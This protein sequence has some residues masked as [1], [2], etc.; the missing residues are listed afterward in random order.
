MQTNQE[1]IKR[2]VDLMKSIMSNPK[3]S[4]TFKDAMAAPIGSTKRAQAKTILSIMKKLG[5]VQNDGVG[6]P[7][8]TNTIENH[9]NPDLSDFSNLMIFPAAPKFR[10]RTPA[11][12]DSK[13]TSGDGQGGPNDNSTSTPPF[14]FSSTYDPAASAS[15]LMKQ[16]GVAQQPVEQPPKPVV[17][18]PVTPASFPN[19]SSPTSWTGSDSAVTPGALAGLDAVKSIAAQPPQTGTNATSATQPGGTTG[20]TTGSTDQTGATTS[21]GTSTTPSSS[22][23]ISTQYPNLSAGDKLKADAQSAVDAGTGPGLFAMGVADNKFG[24]SL[25]QYINNLD[26]KLKTDFN[27][28]PLET[29]LSNLKAE[30]GNLVPTLQTYMTGKDQ[31]MSFIDNMITQAEG[32]LTHTDMGNPAEAA[33][34]T[35]YLN[36]LYTLKGRQNTRY[37]NFLNAAISDYNA[38]V[39]RT[40]ANYDSVYKNYNDA[41]TRGSTIAQTEY[42]TL[43]QT[44]GDLYNSLDQ[45][46]TKRLN[47][48]I[49]QQQK[50]ANALA[51]AKNALDQTN[52]TNPKFWTDVTNLTKQLT[53]SNATGSAQNDLDFTKLGAGGLAGFFAAN[54]YSGS[55]P[56]AA[57]RAINNTM[58]ATLADT[59]TV[60]NVS[61][62]KKLVT[63]LAAAPGGDK[64]AAMLTPTLSQSAYPVVSGYVKS[65]LGTIKKAVQQ[66]VTDKKNGLSNK[67][68]WMSNFSNL[69]SGILEDIYNMASKNIIPGS[70]YEK[71]PSSFVDA[72]FQGSNDSA[73]ASNVTSILMS[74]W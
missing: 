53:D 22:T 58:A 46:P 40:Q 69:D 13:K 45:A 17:P 71:N 48:E 35:N 14:S 73:V 68:G 55:D 37:G 10:A 43:Y 23:P 42:N 63:E 33:N 65:N 9:S 38:D 24:G 62:L 6:G 34:Y 39:D 5:G 16:G 64:A 60:E 67:T 15:N 26:T 66:L 47:L 30:K 59:P 31:Y 28:E 4:K 25:D 21:S 1:H 61:K 50:D 49:L 18:P 72:V 56:Q 27:L 57:A 3:L 54:S 41:L 36:Y 19:L 20:T 44:M 11:S 32:S 52:A 7:S 51:N 74:S 12:V 70:T 29:Q 8:M 2:K